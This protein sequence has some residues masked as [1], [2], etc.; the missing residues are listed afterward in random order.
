M[1]QGGPPKNGPTNAFVTPIKP[2]QTPIRVPTVRCTISSL[3]TL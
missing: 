2:I 3:P 1:D